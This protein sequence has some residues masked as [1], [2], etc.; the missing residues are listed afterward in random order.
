MLMVTPTSRPAQE[1][2]ERQLVLRLRH[3][4]DEE[5]ER[6]ARDDVLVEWVE[7]LLEQVPERNDHQDRAEPEERLPRAEPDDHQR[8]GDQFDEGDRPSDG[9]ERPEREERVLVREEEATD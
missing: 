1:M 9:P 8:S 6:E 3:H 2:V 7:R 5:E 4:E